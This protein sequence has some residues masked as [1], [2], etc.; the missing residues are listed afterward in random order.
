MGNSSEKDLLITP[1]ILYDRVENKLVENG[2]LVAPGVNGNGKKIAQFFDVTPPTV[3]K[4]KLNFPGADMLVTIASRLNVSLDWLLTGK[5]FHKE[6]PTATQKEPDPGEPVQTEKDI[7]DYTVTD[8]C[9]AIIVMSECTD[10]K[11]TEITSN[12]PY[13]FFKGIRIDLIPK[14]SIT[15]LR[16]GKPCFPGFG[17]PYEYKHSTNAV[18]MGV[19]AFLSSFSYCCQSSRHEKNIFWAECLEPS[20]PIQWN[21][22]ETIKGG[23]TYCVYE[24][25]SERAR[26]E[27][28]RQKKCNF[29]QFAKNPDN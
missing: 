3:S 15:P 6:A 17:D 26:R 29:A 1:K 23:K 21:A 14:E 2:Y 12:N 22:I 4:W 9:K 25:R 24:S 19:L 5:D 8:I 18:A 28:L 20:T 10:M 13:N 27:V 11:I 16:W 7:D